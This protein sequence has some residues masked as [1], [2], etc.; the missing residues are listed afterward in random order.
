M[1]AGDIEGR[2]PLTIGRVVQALVGRA[3]LALPSR[4]RESP[5]IMIMWRVI[6]IT[7]RNGYGLS[8][9]RNLQPSFGWEKSQDMKAMASLESLL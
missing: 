5:R 3:I 9:A 7:L 4:R 1:P 8:I 6:L 2:K